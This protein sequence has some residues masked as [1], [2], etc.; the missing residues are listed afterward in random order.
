MSI[1]YLGVPVGAH[2]IVATA[3]GRARLTVGGVAETSAPSRSSGTAR[4]LGYVVPGTLAVVAPNVTY[5]S[6]MLL[7]LADPE[8]AGKY[9]DWIRQRYPGGQVTVAEPS[10]S[11]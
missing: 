1:G 5:G 4:G 3:R 8:R 10:P 7:R 11:R 6:T 2:V 9:A